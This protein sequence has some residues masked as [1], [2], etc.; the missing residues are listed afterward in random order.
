MTIQY[1]VVKKEPLDYRFSRFHDD[2]KEAKDEAERLCRK[3][4]CPF[5]VLMTVGMMSVEKIPVKWDA[6]YASD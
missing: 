5:L 4:G 6:C 2:L 3:E 1:A